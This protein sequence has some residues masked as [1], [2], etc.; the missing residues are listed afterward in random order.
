MA[1]TPDKA[2][3]KPAEKQAGRARFRLSEGVQMVLA[4]VLTFLVATAC[5]LTFIVPSLGPETAAAD[6][7]AGP[8]PDYS[9]PTA[10]EAYVP[11]LEL[12]RES[13]L[14][15][16]LM[17]AA[18]VWSPPFN[19][20]LLSAA[21]SAWTYF[22]YLPSSETMMTVEVGPEGEAV[23]AAME[24]WANPPTVLDDS[25]W[26]AD[27]PAAMAP[28][29][30]ACASALEET[31]GAF[32]ELRLSTAEVNRTVLWKGRVFTAGEAEPLCE[33]TVDAVTGVP[34]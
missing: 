24:D 28:L 30:E 19:D 27:S 18:A 3:G 21:R 16:E 4:F 15:A 31:P 29:V 26:R 2:A 33:V 20:S 22:F 8:A 25:R 6:A 10:R 32:V 23:V 9:I 13:D 1:R 34:R 11:A 7:G 17:S 5:G 14:R 12:A